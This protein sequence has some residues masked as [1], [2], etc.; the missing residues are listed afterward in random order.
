MFLGVYTH[1]QTLR[2]I[3]AVEGSVV[4]TAESKIRWTEHIAPL[5]DERWTPNGICGK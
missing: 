4:S 1:N 2:R 5:A 3:S